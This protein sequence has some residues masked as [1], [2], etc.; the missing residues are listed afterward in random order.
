MSSCKGKKLKVINLDESD[1]LLQWTRRRCEN[2]NHE[3]SVTP[4]ELEACIVLVVWTCKVKLLEELQ[5]E[6]CE[7]P[8]FMHLQ[9]LQVPLMPGTTKP[10]DGCEHVVVGRIVVRIAHLV[11]YHNDL[12]IG[13]VTHPA[14]ERCQ[15]LQV[16]RQDANYSVSANTIP[17]QT[18]NVGQQMQHKDDACWCPRDERVTAC[19]LYPRVVSTIEIEAEK[20]LG[21]SK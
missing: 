7:L 14:R 12:P 15:M 6:Q 11:Y 13:R 2:P 8:S 5:T 17:A 19:I 4:E 1:H 16:S 21:G 18:H 20:D 3:L 10:P 9:A